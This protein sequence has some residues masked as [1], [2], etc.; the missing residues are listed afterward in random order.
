MKDRST[1]SKP[2][3]AVKAF[4]ALPPGCD[5]M[6]SKAQICFAIGVSPRTFDTMLASGD[7]PIH[8]AKVGAFKRWH[9]ATHNAWL[10]K[11]CGKG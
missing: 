3:P 10:A 1:K 8:D 7:Y 11:T 5:A 4:P 6:L 2:K 9:V